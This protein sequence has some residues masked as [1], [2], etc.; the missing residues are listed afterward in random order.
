MLPLHLPDNES[1]THRS[2]TVIGHRVMSSCSEKIHCK[3]WL[4]NTVISDNGTNFFGAA[5]ELKALMNEWDKSKIESDLAQ[6][7]IVLKFNPP[8]A[9]HF[10]GI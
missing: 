3:T 2:Y 6:K 8:G 9:P 5:N 10:G 7:K 1:S 4:P